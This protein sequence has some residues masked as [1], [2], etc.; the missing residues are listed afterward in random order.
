MTVVTAAKGVIGELA[1]GPGGGI[2]NVVP[3]GQ[4]RYNVG[5]GKMVVGCAGGPTQI[6]GLPIF[7]N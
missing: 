5:A 1:A 6:I 2:V 4:A 3:V 7:L